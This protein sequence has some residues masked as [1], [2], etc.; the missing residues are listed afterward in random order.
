MDKF[1]SIKQRVEKQIGSKI[2]EMIQA[3][4][5]R[6]AESR[7]K[8]QRARYGFKKVQKQRQEA[9]RKAELLD[10]YNAK[11]AE[12]YELPMYVTPIKKPLKKNVCKV[13]RFSLTSDEIQKREEFRAALIAKKVNEILDS[14][15]K[16][17]SE[18]PKPKPKPVRKPTTRKKKLT[19]EEIQ[20]IVKNIQQQARDFGWNV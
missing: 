6:K 11:F 15:A 2:D 13:R 4:A 17:K 1:E 19:P 20:E 3:D 14:K 7:R 8:Y 5:K 18:I 10:S 12:S 16:A 9:A